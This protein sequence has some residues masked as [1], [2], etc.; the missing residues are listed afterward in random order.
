MDDMGFLPSFPLAASNMMLV[1]AVLLC[2]LG[3]GQIFVRVLKLP[4]ITGFV[5]TGLV[6]G[7]GVLGLLDQTML[8]ELSIFVDISLGLILFELGRRLDFRWFTH[9]RWLLASSVA[10]SLLSFLFVYGT[11]RF[12][13]IAPVYSATAAAIAMATSPAVLIMIVHDQR[14][15]GPLTERLLALTALNNVFAFLLIA[16]L[17]G[18][19]HLEY[20]ADWLRVVSHPLYLIVGSSAL[21]YVAF[22]VART[23]ARWLGKREDS[24]FG[25]LLGLIVGTVGC[26]ISFKLSVLLALLAF[27]VFAKNL[28]RDHDL[29]AVEFGPGGQFFLVMLFVITGA[30]L[31][32]SELAVA[33]AIGAAFI[34][35]RLA[36]KLIGLGLFAPL[37]GIT[38]KKALLLGIGMVPMS[39]I[40]VVMVQGASALYPE[41]GAKLSSIVLSAV[42]IL[43]LVGPLA[44]QWALRRAG[45]TEPAT[46]AGA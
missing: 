11:L 44:T 32:L 17:F 13:D 39:A 25:M 9:D 3:V 8:G 12:F 19:V 29:M 35:A 42:V 20:R 18:F 22:I 37:S 21:G 43:E 23:L 33:G 4:R 2:G 28:D 34:L 14:A 26:A 38:Q 6:L 1:G 46:G 40:A 36:G 7:P 24:Q 45:E 15:T 41:F 10:E 27:G 5:A 31:R 30:G 16:L